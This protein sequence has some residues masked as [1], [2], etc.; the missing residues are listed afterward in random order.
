MKIALLGHGTVGRGVDDIIR[1]RVPD[2]EVARILELPDRLSDPRMTADYSDIVNDPSIEL[3]VECMGGIEPAHKFIKEALLVKKHVVTS[4]KAV[5]AAHF[6]EFVQLASQA[7]VAFLIEASVG[8][9]IPWIA[10]IDKVRRIDDVMSFSGIMNGTTNYI[11]DSMRRDGLDFGIALGRAQELGYAER[12]PSADIDGID[13][14]NK[15]I[16]SA[17]VAFDV[18]CVR[19]LPVTG[20]R[21]LTKADLDMFAARGLTV[22]L[23]GRG[24]C[25]EGRYAVA[26]EPVAIPV[27]SL[28]AA[29]PS[30]FNLV[31]CEGFTVGPLKFYGQGAGSLPTGNAIVQDVIDVLQ[32]RRQTYDFSKGYVYDPSLLT[33]DYVI[34]ATSVPV[35]CD[36]WGR[37][38]W[39]VR[40]YTAQQARRLFEQVLQVDASAFMAAL[41]QEG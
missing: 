10:S 37:N 6:D 29:V 26:V 36:A 31:S 11:I 25:R 9:G 41:P 7:D 35:R 12:D 14:A 32:G 39:R 21:T 17:C 13:V 30:N 28:E 34:R 33:S 23:F 8:G 20:I 5:V 24:V 38:A 18:D 40:H 1:D 15:T 3:V 2:I 19:D 27:T 16:I 22:K 4:N